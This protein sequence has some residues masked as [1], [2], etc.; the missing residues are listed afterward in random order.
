AQ[1]IAAQVAAS[2]EVSR[3]FAEERSQR[4]VADTLRETANALSRSLDEAT[5]PATVLDQLRT[6]FDYEGAAIALVVDG[7]LVLV[8]A[9]GL[10]QQHLGRQIPLDSNTASVVVLKSGQQLLIDDTWQC[11]VWAPWS[12]TSEIRSWLG[13]PLVA[14]GEPIGVM[15]LDSTRVGAFS[16]TQAD[17]LVSFAN[18]AAIAVANARY[19]RSAQDAAAASERERIA[20]DLHDAVT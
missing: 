17:L 14:N 2:L 11:S 3:L 16:Q 20:R 6:V 9:E 13:V 4:Q 5:V 10:S 12:T 15:N 1:T 8:A 18:Q 19:H 7:A